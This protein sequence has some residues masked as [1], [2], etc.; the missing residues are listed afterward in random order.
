[1]GNGIS[2]PQTCHREKRATLLLS[3]K[4]ILDI[5]SFR[6]INKFL[7][8]TLQQSPY[9][10]AIKVLVKNPNALVKLVQF[11]ALE[12]VHS[13]N[14]PI[15]E[16]ITNCHPNCSLKFDM[17]FE[18]IMNT[19]KCSFSNLS[20]TIEND[21]STL[22]TFTQSVFIEFLY[23]QYFDDWRARE[24]SE[25]INS[26]NEYVKVECTLP[27]LE[28]LSCEL[29][30]YKKSLIVAS[31]LYSDEVMTT[32]VSA[33]IIRNP[34]NMTLKTQLTKEPV[35]IPVND[36][37][38]NPLF[39]FNQ[40]LH[41]CDPIE[42]PKL[43]KYDRDGWITSFLIAAETL[44]IGI[45]LSS[46]SRE[47]PGFPVIYLNKY[48]SDQSGHKREDV[49]GQRFGFMQRTDA[50]VLEHSE[51]SVTLATVAVNTAQSVVVFID[52]IHHNNYYSTIVGIKP[53]FD[54]HGNYKFVIGLHL[55]I[56]KTTNAN[57]EGKMRMISYMENLFEFKGKVP[58]GHVR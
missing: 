8:I 33:K 32:F 21:N 58:L 56:L 40:M 22:A 55:E 37:N 25:A 30:E 17:I 53:I 42:V 24:T 5:S 49:L 6:G 57:I 44:P 18:I 46:I 1:M 47:R 34:S 2:S 7:Q 10:E 19:L 26:L 4:E 52:I 29:D 54:S 3:T 31:V 51:P 11:L 23:S 50:R 39:K 14:S 45:T 27:E 16:S 13:K 41:N 15:I 12:L 9:D 36:D 38:T 48:F 28:F 35:G 20:P 43:L